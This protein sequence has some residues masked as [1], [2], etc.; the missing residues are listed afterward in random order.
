MTTMKRKRTILILVAIFLICSSSFAHAVS[1][2]GILTTGCVT[3]SSSQYI[4]YGTVGQSVIG[5][6]SDANWNT[7]AG[8]LSQVSLNIINPIPD[9]VEELTFAFSLSEAYPNP[10]NPITTINF[11]LARESHVSLKVYNV[12]GQNVVAL[13]DEMMPA[14]RY[15]VVWN[16][17]NMPTGLYFY[18]LKADGYSETKKMMLVK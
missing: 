13:K 1:S 7:D 15:S 4:T 3:A 6:V 5:K 9:K 10:F 11:S 17:V 14:G 12:T 16:A 2:Y 8:F 18:A